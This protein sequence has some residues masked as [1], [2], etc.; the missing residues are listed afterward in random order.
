MFKKVDGST[1]QALNNINDA[2]S[3]FWLDIDEDGT[4]DIVVQRAGRS[5]GASRKIT[6][7]KNNFYHDAFFLKTLCK[8]CVPGAQLWADATTQ[9]Q[10]VR[11]MESVLAR[12][13]RNTM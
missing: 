2:K 12:T 9:S 6:F 10:T 13:A 3:A 11:V 8:S 1:A 7:I 5:S 4:L